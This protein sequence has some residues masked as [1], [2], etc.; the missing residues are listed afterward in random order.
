M[1]AALSRQL[2]AE[3]PARALSIYPLNT[4]ARIALIGEALN[5]N[6]DAVDVEDETRRGLVLDPVDARFFSILAELHQRKGD[7]EKAHALFQTAHRIS[8]TEH[9]ALKNLIRISVENG[10]YGEAVRTADILFRRWPERFSELAPFIA[11][12]ITQEEAYAVFLELSGEG[13]PWRGRLISFLASDEDFSP[14][15]HRLLLDLAVTEVPPTRAEKAALLNGYWR[16]RA[17]ADA[18]RLFLMTLSEEERSL[19]GFVHNAGFSEAQEPQLF[20]WSYRNTP[21]ADIRFS[22]APAPYNGAIVR[23]LDKPAREVVL[24]QNLVLPQGSFRLKVDTSAF[25]LRTPRDLFLTVNCVRPN[26]ELARLQL[27]EGNYRDNTIELDFE[28]A[29]CPAQTIR[30]ETGLVAESWRHRYSGQIVL[31]NV[32]I[33]R[34][35]G[36]QDRS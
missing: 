30:L 29:D 12:L 17:Y 9:H 26:R 35:V 7:A 32:A 28:V 31:H 8:H 5:G 10:S 3:Y 19:T 25:S 16:Q 34:A 24:R 14:L 11:T 21:E 33:T 1:L 27:P 2:E 6:E 4:E 13:L 18:Y 20:A 36:E 15:A 22:S 23:F